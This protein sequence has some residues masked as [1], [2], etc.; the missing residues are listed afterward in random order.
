[1]AETEA[2]MDAKSRMAGYSSMEMM[3]FQVQLT[4][5]P[6]YCIQGA[7]CVQHPREVTTVMFINMEKSTPAPLVDSAVIGY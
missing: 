5:I 4:F 6:H 2:V 3:I 1:M 7:F